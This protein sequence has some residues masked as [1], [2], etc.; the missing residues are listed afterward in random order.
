[1][2]EDVGTGGL[3]FVT[4]DSGVTVCLTEGDALE[5]SPAS[6][7]APGIKQ[8]HNAALGGEMV[9]SREGGRLLAARGD[10]LYRLTMM[11]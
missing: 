2:V 6:K 1:M 11:T 5:L 3:N 7:G 4:L 8:V 9:L 10:R